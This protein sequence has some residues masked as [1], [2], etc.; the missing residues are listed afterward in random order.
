MR[1]EENLH[2]SLQGGIPEVGVSSDSLHVS[3]LELSDTLAPFLLLQA[4]TQDCDLVLEDVVA[5]L[6]PA[7]VNGLFI[8]L[9]VNMRSLCWDSPEDLGL[10][11]S[12][13]MGHLQLKLGQ[14]RLSIAG[15]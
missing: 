13:L 3:D 14:E 5:A 10:V 7:E 8:Q 15:L 4:D 6:Q 11:L 9:F 2:L 1:L 12:P